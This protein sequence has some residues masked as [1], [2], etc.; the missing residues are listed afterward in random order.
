MANW[1]FVTNHGVVLALVAQHGQITTREIA[2]DLGITE[3][4]VH[5]IL[6]D[7]ETAGYIHR[8]RNGRLNT[9]EVNRAL[10]LYGLQRQEIAIGELLSVLLAE[11]KKSDRTQLEGRRAQKE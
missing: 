3:R 8:Q 1:S 11:G 9:Y 7:L 4:T 6:S 2:S 5:R 10:P